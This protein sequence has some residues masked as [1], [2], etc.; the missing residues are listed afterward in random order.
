MISVAAEAI[1]GTAVGLPSAVF[2]AYA[3]VQAAK[4]KRKQVEYQAA[5]ERRRVDAEAYDRAK[6]IYE[7]LVGEL[8]AQLKT[9]RTQTR[10]TQTAYD[11]LQRELWKEQRN[12]TE[13]N[14]QILALEAKMH[15][16]TQQVEDMEH[17]ISDM[18]RR[19]IAAGLEPSE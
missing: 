7:S 3:A 8:E 19:L 6:K 10:E 18:R 17:T 14:T 13:R 2:A 9:L 11:N 5:S 12:V 16:M 1:S 4:V 15:A